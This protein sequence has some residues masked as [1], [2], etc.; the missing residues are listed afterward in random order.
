MKRV[1]G[2]FLI[3][4]ALVSPCL[5]LKKFLG[6]F[7]GASSAGLEC[8]EK[9][10]SIA[11]D[12]RI[13]AQKKELPHW[14]KDF[15]RPKKEFPARAKEFLAG[16]KEF[17]GAKKKFPARPKEFPARAKEFFAG[18]KDFPAPSEE[19]TE[20]RKECA[21]G[22]DCFTPD[23]APPRRIRC[24]FPLRPSKPRSPKMRN[25]DRLSPSSLKVPA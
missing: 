6:K 12:G 13:F 21:V 3:A 24:R 4:V 9:F 19:F 2:G 16:S 18:T 15:P 10:F 1:L 20:R 14:T 25:P 8:R 5:R 17:P 22:A 7:F 23:G 11:R